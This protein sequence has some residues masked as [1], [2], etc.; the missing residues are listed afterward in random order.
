M[1]FAELNFNGCQC[2][3]KFRYTVQTPLWLVYA[4]CK[5]DVRCVCVEQCL[6][7]FAVPIACRPATARSPKQAGAPPRARPSSV[8]DLASPVTAFQIVCSLSLA[9]AHGRS[10]HSRRCA[11]STKL[12]RASSATF[13]GCRIP[14]QP[15]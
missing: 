14:I 9:D 13:S 10:F 5:T 15:S 12:R 4:V 6:N 11:L 8:T 2:H 1:T 7:S 3:D